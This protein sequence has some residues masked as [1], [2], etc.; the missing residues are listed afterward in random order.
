MKISA[1]LTVNIKNV[2]K[3]LGTNK[4]ALF[5]SMTNIIILLHLQ[6]PKNLRLDEY[7]W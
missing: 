3:L 2:E 6:S 1:K 7:V 4:K 5:K